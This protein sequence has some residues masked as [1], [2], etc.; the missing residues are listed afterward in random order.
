[1]TICNTTPKHREC[2]FVPDTTTESPQTS[3]PIPS[4]SAHVGLITAL[5]ISVV[6]SILLLTILICKL[7]SMFYI[8]I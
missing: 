8:I 3:T 1:M 6:V 2:H 5:I 4:S 7:F